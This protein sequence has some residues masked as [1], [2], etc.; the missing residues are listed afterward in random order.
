MVSNSFKESVKN[1]E[2]GKIRSIF[3]IIFSKRSSSK[4]ITEYLDYCLSNGIDRDSLF[5]D[6]DGELLLDDVKKWNADS[7]LYSSWH[8]CCSD[9]IN[10]FFKIG[11][12]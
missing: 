3:F 10:I 11:K 1:K 7:D 4:E 9:S 5:V 6:H 12:K 8:Y 2:I